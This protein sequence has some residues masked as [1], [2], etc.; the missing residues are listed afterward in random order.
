MM[1]W[2]HAWL[3]WILGRRWCVDVFR[4]FAAN[5]YA[6]SRQH[7]DEAVI[8]EWCANHG[9]IVLIIMFLIQIGIIVKDK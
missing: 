7:M 3:E 1:D 5:L 9:I 8:A 2:R 4:Y 6:M